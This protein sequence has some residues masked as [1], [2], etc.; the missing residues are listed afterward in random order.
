[1]SIKP[2]DATAAKTG[3]K[4]QARTTVA[5]G[6]ARRYLAPVIRTF[7]E[8]VLLRKAERTREAMARRTETL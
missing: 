7:P 6:T 8:A 4:S 3:R 5:L 1:M 2:H